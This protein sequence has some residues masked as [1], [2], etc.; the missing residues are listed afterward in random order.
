MLIREIRLFAMQK[1]ILLPK[2]AKKADL[3]HCIQKCEG[4]TACYAAQKCNN[5][6][7]L[8]YADCQKQ[9]KK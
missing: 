9:A 3:I 4:N 1:N 8:W 6:V 7:C 5:T 2:R